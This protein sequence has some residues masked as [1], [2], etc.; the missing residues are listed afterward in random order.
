MKI[1]VVLG[2]AGGLESE[3]CAHFGQCSHFLIVEAE[4]GRI[5]SSR[6]VPNGAQHGGGGCQAVGEILKH[7]VTHVIAGGMG[8]G[9]QG[10]FAAAGVAVFGFAGKAG[11]GV[12][13]LLASSLEKGI[14]PCQDHHGDCHR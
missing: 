12:A 2:D 4:G 5:K 14:A 9:A 1:G 3:V 11:D 10:K 7:K 13:Q 6:V 8:M